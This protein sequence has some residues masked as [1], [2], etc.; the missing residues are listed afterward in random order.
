[1]N[2]EQW[3][4]YIDNVRVP[5]RILA[6]MTWDQIAYLVARRGLEEPP[7]DG[8]D[9]IEMLPELIHYS[10]LRGYEVEPNIEMQDV[11][12]WRIMQRLIPDDEL[13]MHVWNA[14]PVY[15][16]HN[17]AR[18]QATDIVVS[19]VGRRKAFETAVRSGR[20]DKA[21]Q[22]FSRRYMTQEVIDNVLMNED[23]TMQLLPRVRSGSDICSMLRPTDTLRSYNAEWLS[24]LIRCNVARVEPNALTRYV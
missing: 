11:S 19:L 20:I 13:L 14:E 15:D 8:M 10:R 17:Q 18:L 23:M 2:E 4:Y 1:M 6:I 21:L 9:D 24:T 16:A 22:Y 7:P 5:L 3:K 12:Y